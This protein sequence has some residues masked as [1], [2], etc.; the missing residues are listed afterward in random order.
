MKSQKKNTPTPK[1]KSFDID[2]MMDSS[3]VFYASGEPPFQPNTFKFSPPSP[4]PLRPAIPNGLQNYTTNSLDLGEISPDA[5]GFCLEE[6]FDNSHGEFHL[7]QDILDLV[8]NKTAVNSGTSKKINNPSF[9]DGWKGLGPAHHLSI[10]L[11]D[12]KK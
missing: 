12:P 8:K 11:G 9:Q 10:N 3:H 1:F 4:H 6:R 5:A 2:D 7:N